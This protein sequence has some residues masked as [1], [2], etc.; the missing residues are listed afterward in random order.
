[1]TEAEIQ[2]AIATALASA[3]PRPAWEGFTTRELAVAQGIS[4]RAM[5]RRLNRLLDE[6]TWETTMG[7]R[8]DSMGRVQHVPIY[9]PR[10]KRAASPKPTKGKK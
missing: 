5:Q 4:D 1:M 2:G 10:V 7:Q 6:G 8:P 9:R 3:F